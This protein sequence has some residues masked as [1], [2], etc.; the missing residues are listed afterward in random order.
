[1]T[2]ATLAAGPAVPRRPLERLAPWALLLPALAI[3]LVFFALPAL[4]MLRMSFNIHPPDRIYVT[5]WSLENYARLLADPLY[6]ASLGRTLLLALV[7]ATVTV[8]FA[9]VFSLYI[10]LQRGPRKLI[11]LAI[12]LC[13]LL[14]SEISVI[15]GWWMFFPNNGLM[16]VALLELGLIEEKISLMYT[17]F[18]AV[19][20]LTYITLPFGIFILLSILDGVDRRVLEASDDLGAS[21]LRTFR[22]VLLP[23]TKGGI[24]VAFSQAFIWTMGTYATPSALGP[25]WLWTIGFEIYRQMSSW[26]NWPFASVLALFLV[27][28]VLA[29][30]VLTRRITARRTEFHA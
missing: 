5:A 14:I 20:G 2:A 24:A 7:T 17:V 26:R 29:M 27:M 12:A 10:W 15:F 23:L 11:F 30:M 21:P 22:E 16:S 19:V 18:A 4:Y 9:Y 25:D 1:M 6:L 13:P 28:S 8:A 3:V